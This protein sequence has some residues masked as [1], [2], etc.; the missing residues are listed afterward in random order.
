MTSLERFYTL[1]LTKGGDAVKRGRE[2]GECLPRSIDA[3]SFERN[4]RKS[5]HRRS[6][7]PVPGRI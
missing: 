4:V 5:S 3:A 1:K 2:T 7:Q 6:P